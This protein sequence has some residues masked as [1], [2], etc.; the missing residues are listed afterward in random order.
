DHGLFATQ[1]PPGQLIW[2]QP[3]VPG[4]PLDTPSTQ[5]VRV[6]DL[7]SL[8]SGL[9][10]YAV[11]G[12]ASGL[13][14]GML[15]GSP[16]DFTAALLPDG[17]SNVSGV[18]VNL[19]PV[20]SVQGSFGMAVVQLPD[21]GHGVLGALPVEDR[22]QA[23]SEWRLNPTLPSA[24]ASADLEEVSCAAASYCVITVN[25]SGGDNLLI[26]SN[27]HPPVISTETSVV[28][29]EG[30]SHPL[31]V[32]VSDDDGDAVRVTSS[33]QGVLSPEWTL[34]PEPAT[35]GEALRLLITGGTV[36]EDTVVSSAMDGGLSIS[37]TDGLLAHEVKLP[38]EIQVKHTQVP[39]AP[40]VSPSQPRIAAGSTS[41]LVLTATGMPTAAG[42]LPTGFRWRE[43]ADGG[44][45]REGG[46]LAF[47]APRNVCEAAGVDYAHELVA[48]DSAG[49]SQPTPFSV[50]VE[51]W[52]P[53]EPAFGADAGVS[54][55]AGEPLF[56]GPQA[57][58]VCQGAGG[59][60]GVETTW[61]LAPGTTSPQGVEF[62]ATDGGVVQLPVQA[63]MLGVRSPACVDARFRLSA[64]NRLRDAGTPGAA[65][66][67]EVTV[68]PRLRP[69]ASGELTL[70]AEQ[71]AVGELA[72]SMNSDL[73]CPGRRGLYAE[74]RLERVAG[75]SEP[76]SGSVSVP[77][78]VRLALPPGC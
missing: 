41:P 15:Q 3:G 2:F 6:V 39:A 70:Q 1:S 16:N 65:S 19:E 56:F 10:P 61:S 73:D 35:Q 5:V 40:Q 71:P 60:P 22:T 17:L 53:P 69:L 54:V 31:E 46:T 78:S 55:N 11:F 42:C 29:G 9:A 43:L 47:Q 68:A 38:I 8:G 72:L 14:R 27:E 67:V 30:E 32:F 57:L 4:A 75:G 24:F 59:F 49:E 18:D 7:S 25:R 64:E 58:H 52:G 63:G 51:P 12:S 37:A 74:L 28:V 23:G 62:L 76:V 50:H 13:Y 77:G 34:S 26:Y 36:C 66:E 44:S 33:P 21:G 48:Y 45:V 20:G